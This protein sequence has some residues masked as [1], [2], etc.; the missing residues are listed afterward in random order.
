MTGVSPP[1]WS[2][3]MDAGSWRKFVQGRASQ[4]AKDPTHAN[5]NSNVG[6]MEDGRGRNRTEMTARVT[7]R[8]NLDGQ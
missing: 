4:P 1:S 8:R 2:G 6:W 7:E 5:A 3:V